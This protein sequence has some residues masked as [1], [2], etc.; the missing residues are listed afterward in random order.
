MV[1]VEPVVVQ[2]GASRQISE[3]LLASSTKGPYAEIARKMARMLGSADTD[4]GGSQPSLIADLVNGRYRRGSL[5]PV[6][7]PASTPNSSCGSEGIWATASS[8][9]SSRATYR[10][11][12]AHDFAA[13]GK[14]S[15]RSPKRGTT[16]LSGPLSL[17]TEACF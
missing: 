4:G 15:A 17:P 7:S 8:T 9:G 5:A 10:A 14:T 11:G 13:E 1:I 6:T 3:A 12:Q 2:T 16:P